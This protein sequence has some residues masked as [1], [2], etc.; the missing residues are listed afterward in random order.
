MAS[1]KVGRPKKQAKD[2]QFKCLKVMM[3][4]EDFDKISRLADALSVSK[5][6]LG[7]RALL[8]LEISVPVSAENLKARRELAVLGNNLNQAMLGLNKLLKF[9]EL[10][11]KD[12]AVRLI[13]P[14]TLQEQVDACT[15]TV[16]ELTPLIKEMRAV[17][18]HKLD[19]VT[20]MPGEALL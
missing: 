20:R 7:R 5:S 11:D 1:N 16:Q 15:H 14:E 9:I 10:S 2:L 19:E 18:I 3:S 6:E 8:E 4:Q 13:D 17:L 12:H